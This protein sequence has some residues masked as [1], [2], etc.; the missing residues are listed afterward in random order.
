[1]RSKANRIERVSPLNRPEFV[2]KY[3]AV[4]QYFFDAL[5]RSSFW[6]S[7]HDK[8]NDPLDCK[9]ELSDELLESHFGSDSKHP[10]IRDFA[11]NAFIWGVCCFTTDPV[12]YLMWSHYAAGHTG[13]CLEFRTR[14]SELLLNTLHP[15]TYSDESRVIKTM[16]EYPKAFFQ[17]TTHWAY[18]KEWRL[19]GGGDEYMSYP[20]VALSSITFGVKA[21]ADTIASVISECKK[22]SFQRTSFFRI[23]IASSGSTLVREPLPG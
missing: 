6:F 18:E 1:M 14:R 8:L 4:N 16:D 22:A 3:S 23:R 9:L 5:S 17:K 2:Y 13:V 11:V 21:T 20:R 7:H 19:L 15:V 12:N 10:F